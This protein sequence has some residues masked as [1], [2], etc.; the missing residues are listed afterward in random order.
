MNEQ[1][2]PETHDELMEQTALA[3][4]GEANAV[5]LHEL[6]NTLNNVLLQAKLMQQSASPE[7]QPRLADTCK[8]IL[9]AAQHMKHLAQFRQSRRTKPYAV[10]LN[11][12]VECVARSAQV[13][14]ELAEGLPPLKSTVSDL[15]RVVSLL[16]KNATSTGAPTEPVGVATSGKGDQV[17]LLVQ[18]NGMQVDAEALPQLFDPFHAP[19]RLPDSLELSICRELMRRMR[20]QLTADLQPAGLAYT[21]SWTAT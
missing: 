13:R 10:D 1:A 3:D 2:R 9:N 21:A 17:C 12:V 20:G 7:L 4:A 16:V 5:F 11:G 15:K 14:L 8:H 19:G 6:G 18:S